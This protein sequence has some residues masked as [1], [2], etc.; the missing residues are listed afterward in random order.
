[1]EADVAP[2]FFRAAATA[3]SN[4]QLRAGL[5]A[6]PKRPR[7][8]IRKPGKVRTARPF[9]V[10]L[11][12]KVIARQYAGRLA[13]TDGV[14][15]APNVFYNAD[16]AY[17]RRLRLRRRFNA[18]ANVFGS[19][20]AHWTYPMPVKLNNARNIYTIHDL[21]PLR[22]PFATLDQKRVY[23]RMIERLCR[24]ADMIVTVSETSRR[25]ILSFFDIA[26]EKVVN[27]YQSVEIPKRFLDIDEHVLKEELLGLHDVA[28][29]G[30]VLF[31]GAVEPKKNLARLME[32]YMSSGLDM[33]LLIVGKDGWLFEK[34]M[35]LL[36]MPSNCYEV[37]RDGVT[38][39]RQRIRRIDY[40]SFPQ[41]INLV[42][43][44]RMVA[45][46]SLYEGFGLPI[47]EAMLCGTPVMTADLGATCEVAGD[48]AV[49][50]D[51]YDTRAIRDA[52]IALCRDDELCATM[53]AKGRERAK[54]FS[55][56]L[57]A[58]R[59]NAVYMQA[60]KP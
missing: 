13:V 30:Y 60:T 23:Y 56:E 47:V 27:T 9:S 53:T 31:Y 20:V 36:D 32:A 24:E 45:M 57:H 44:A 55:P 41:L 40:V 19:D 42:R 16:I 54:A 3:R 51:P 29:K 33:P 7:R 25:D 50:V 11:E 12:G 52:M 22:L 15:N 37:E 21:V 46:P 34:D 14:W 39:R 26:P 59:L 1:M 4:H 28:Y 48:A 49:L 58:E 38:T 2:L 17:A 18:I 10:P 35:E 5:A 8:P 43:G 6:D